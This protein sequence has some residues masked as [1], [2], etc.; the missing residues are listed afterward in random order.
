MLFTEVWYRN[1]CYAFW[2][3]EIGLCDRTEE[4][5]KFLLKLKNN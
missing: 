5:N 3:Y 2:R 1:E 4:A